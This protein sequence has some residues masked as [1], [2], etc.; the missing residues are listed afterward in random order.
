MAQSE[1]FFYSCT[2]GPLSLISSA[3]DPW[4]PSWW[5]L[6]LPWPGWFATGPSLSSDDLWIGGCHCHC[7]MRTL[8]DL[9]LVSTDH[10][11]MIEKTKCTYHCWSRARGCCQPSI[12]G[13][14]CTIVTI[15]LIEVIHCHS[16]PHPNSNTSSRNS[17]SELRFHGPPILAH[18]GKLFI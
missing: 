6:P 7:I 14:Q 3:N 15:L 9:L 4:S 8:P 5:L 18:P 12:M 17:P 10:I 11:P 13:N 2:I 16:G 1:T